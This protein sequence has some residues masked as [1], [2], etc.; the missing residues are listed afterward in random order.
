MHAC[1]PMAVSGPELVLEHIYLPV[2]VLYLRPTCS[3]QQKGLLRKKTK[4]CK[5]RQ[6]EDKEAQGIHMMK[7]PFGEKKKAR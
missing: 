7:G 6:G 4:N 1:P 2:A 5:A 3:H